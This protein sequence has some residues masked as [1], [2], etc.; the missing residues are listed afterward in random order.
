MGNPFILPLVTTL[1]IFFELKPETRTRGRSSGWYERLNSGRPWRTAGWLG[2]SL[3]TL[4]FVPA[5]ASLNLR[6]D[7]NL[8]A[9]VAPPFL[10]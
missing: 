8:S 5:W 4:P 1:P 9:N 2:L 7:F 3:M 6:C 10:L